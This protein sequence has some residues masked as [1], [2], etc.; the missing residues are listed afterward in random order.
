[1]AFSKV[2]TE[3]AYSGLQNATKHTQNIKYIVCKSFHKLP[4]AFQH[5]NEWTANG[6]M[7]IRAASQPVHPHSHP[8]TPHSRSTRSL[9]CHSVEVVCAVSLAC[10]LP[11][12]A[13]LGA[14]SRRYLT[15]RPCVIP[16]AEHLLAWLPAVPHCTG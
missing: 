1:V 15:L 2:K 10:V 14:L 9:V 5:T 4:T 16:A 3:T 13:Q 12:Y 11:L 6:L 7:A 8:F